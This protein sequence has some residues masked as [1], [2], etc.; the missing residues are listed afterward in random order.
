MSGRSVNEIAAAALA[1][2]F[3]GVALGRSSSKT[4]PARRV[5]SGRS[6]DEIITAAER[7]VAESGH[8]LAANA[9]MRAASERTSGLAGAESD[10][11]VK[12]ATDAGNK[13][14]TALKQVRTDPAR[15][16]ADCSSARM[17]QDYAT[18]IA[19]ERRE[20]AKDEW[21]ECRTT[22]DRFDKILVDLR[23]TG[24]SFVTVIIGGAAFLLGHPTQSP[25]SAG[26]NDQPVLKLWIY[27]AIAVLVV[28]LFLIDRIHQ[29]W[30]SVAVDRAV[31]IEDGL[32]ICL[33]K[34]LQSDVRAWMAFAVG[35]VLYG[36]LLSGASGIFLAALSSPAH[37]H[38]RLNGIQWTVV[39]T[40]VVG[41]ACT[42]I[43]A[44]LV[45][46]VSRASSSTAART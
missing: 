39:V 38:H 23:K 34:R 7:I 27:I 37:L 20:A 8:T 17:L 29:M 44:P 15:A 36:L 25:G 2:F 40:W 14:R 28:G 1:G 12:A 43:G 5:M 19:L 24:I 46:S 16:D 9:A 32:G 6:V 11:V 31:E 42:V 21:K 3:C 45:T 41:V 26:P 4:P 18:A 10:R 35:F 33:T 13:A 30:L 22:I